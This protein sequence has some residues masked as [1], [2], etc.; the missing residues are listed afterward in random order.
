MQAVG[1]APVQFM[2]VVL[3]ACH[4][5]GAAAAAAAAAA[6]PAAM[7][8]S[9]ESR[10]ASE[11]AATAGAIADRDGHK[12]RLETAVAERSAALQKLATLEARFIAAEGLAVGRRAGEE[13]DE[14]GHAIATGGG[15]AGGSL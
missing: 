1:F 9:F 15:G 11:R 6:T 4:E 14:L 8:S 7:A 2:G 12:S 13:L 3:K 10:L 5:V